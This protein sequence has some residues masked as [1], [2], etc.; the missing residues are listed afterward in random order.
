[1][2]V[3]KGDKMKCE[4]KYIKN[5]FIKTLKRSSKTDVLIATL[6]SFVACTAI[7]YLFNCFALV[8]FVLMLYILIPILNFKNAVE[9]CKNKKG[10]KNG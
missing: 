2:F 7:S 6:V 4:L 1:M 5:D 8:L 3:V 9:Y 10:D